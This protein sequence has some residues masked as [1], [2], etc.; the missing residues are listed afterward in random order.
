MRSNRR[1]TW[2]TCGGTLLVVLGLYGTHYGLRATRAYWLYHHAKYGAGQERL[3]VIMRAIE[4]A[5][6]F[7]PHNYR[8]CTWAA[9]RA[10]EARPGRDGEERERL[11]RASENWTDV[12]LALNRYSGPLHLLKARLI[13]S[14]DPAAA[15]AWWARYLEWHFWEPYNHAVLFDLYLDAGNLEKAAQS[16]DWLENTAHFASASER[17]REAW[18]K[19]MVPPQG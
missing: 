15:A 10:Y 11:T 7:Y 14:R 18:R 6:R 1:T 2:K 16:L 12:G 5:H 19:E 4:Q 9:Q 3:P 8:F 17:Y 13:Q